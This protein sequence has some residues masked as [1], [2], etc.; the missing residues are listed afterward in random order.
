VKLVKLSFFMGTFSS[1]R[2]TKDVAVDLKQV[3]GLSIDDGMPCQTV[4]I[5]VLIWPER[6]MVG[7]N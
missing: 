5:I 1:E 3:V 7:E 6:S 4:L 2:L